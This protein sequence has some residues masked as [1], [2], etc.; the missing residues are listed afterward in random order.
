[1]KVNLT[2]RSV[3][4]SAGAIMVGIAVGGIARLS[5]DKLQLFEFSPEVFFFVLLPPIIF[6][7][8]YSLDR[9]GF[10]ENIVSH[11]C[12]EGVVYDAFYI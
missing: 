4:V 11:I 3:F 2:I 8:G 9:K 1:M 7:A 10:F 12:V 5:T 6:E